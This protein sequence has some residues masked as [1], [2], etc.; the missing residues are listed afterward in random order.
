M[1][2]LEVKEIRKKLGMNQEEFADLLEVS[3]RTII[4]YE[5]SAKLKPQIEQYIKYMIDKKGMAVHK[6]ETQE[7]F[8]EIE[9]KI[10]QINENIVR[11]LNSYLDVQKK[12]NGFFDKKDSKSG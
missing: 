7:R 3:K 1:N 8:A 5:Q 6:D 10:A 9:R 2:G 11:L 4:N 12:M